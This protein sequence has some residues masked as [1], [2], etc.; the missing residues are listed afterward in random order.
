MENGFISA[1]EPAR[2][3]V[4]TAARVVAPERR[5]STD[6]AGAEREAIGCCTCKFLDGG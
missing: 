5:P 6:V 3:R 1:A 2:R 4:R